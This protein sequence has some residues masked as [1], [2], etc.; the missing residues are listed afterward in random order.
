MKGQNMGSRNQSIDLFRHAY[1]AN[2]WVAYLKHSCLS[3]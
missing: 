1:D 2:L 3:I